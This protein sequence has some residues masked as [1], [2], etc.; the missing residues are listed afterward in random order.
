MLIVSLYFGQLDS[1][2]FFI[3]LTL[4]CEFLQQW[5]IRWLS[6]LLFIENV[7]ELVNQSTYLF[8]IFRS[9]LAQLLFVFLFLAK[10]LAHNHLCLTPEVSVFPLQ[11]VDLISIIAV[12]VNENV[13]ICL[14]L[15]HFGRLFS[16]GVGIHLAEN[17][18]VVLI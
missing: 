13:D 1:S 12:V 16:V 14:N 10:E 15:C 8:T 11:W 2:C 4:V 17:S 6:L 5:L 3:K 7:F 18:I 9:C